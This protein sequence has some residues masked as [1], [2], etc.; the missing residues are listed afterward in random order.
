MRMDAGLDTGDM[1]LSSR[2]GH[3]ARYE[4]SG[5]LYDALADEG[6]LL[7]RT[8]PAMA[9]GTLKPCRSPR[10]A[11]AMLPMLNK[12]PSSPGLEEAGR[13]HPQLRCEA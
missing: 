4:T 12:K 1:L 5:E 11:N 6:A 13:P 7:S 8:L 3:S 2:L 9:A 10:K